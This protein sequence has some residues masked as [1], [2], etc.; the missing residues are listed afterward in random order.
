MACTV[1]YARAC[2]GRFNGRAGLGE[3]TPGASAFPNPAPRG[4]R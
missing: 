1:N 3:E 4:R 2:D